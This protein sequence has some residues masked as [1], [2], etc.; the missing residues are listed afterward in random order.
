MICAEEHIVSWLSES[1]NRLRELCRLLYSAGLQ[2]RVN[3]G[4][5]KKGWTLE[6][7]PCI[8]I[9]FSVLLFSLPPGGIRMVS[10]RFLPLKSCFLCRFYYSQFAI[11][12]NASVK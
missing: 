9:H 7:S 8:M 1:P 2:Y 11:G 4:L 10:E 5:E 12:D 3:V 6:Q